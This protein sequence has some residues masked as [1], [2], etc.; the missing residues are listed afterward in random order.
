[1]HVGGQSRSSSREDPHRGARYMD[2]HRSS[3][4]G[5]RRGGNQDDYNRRNNDRYGDRRR[6]N[7]SRDERDYRGRGSREGKMPRLSEPLLSYKA[8]LEFQ[9]YGLSR[10]EA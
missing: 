10:E 9:Q 4:P 3:G 2:K 7:D 6:R 8:F 5:G 1:M